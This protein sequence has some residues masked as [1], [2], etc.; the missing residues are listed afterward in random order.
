MKFKKY[1]KTFTNRN[2][3]A[4]FN[5]RKYKEVGCDLV[6]NPFSCDLE[7]CDLKEQYDKLIIKAE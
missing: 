2:N 6:N 7:K 5:C 3:D 4:T 1:L